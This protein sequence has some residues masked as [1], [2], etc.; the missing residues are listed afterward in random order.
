MRRYAP[1]NALEHLKLLQ[2]QLE[3]YEYSKTLRKDLY[4]CL[5]RFLAK[6]LSLCRRVLVYQIGLNTEPLLFRKQPCWW[7]F[8]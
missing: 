8:Y 4:T 2:I 5:V 1:K 6:Y 7:I 3:T